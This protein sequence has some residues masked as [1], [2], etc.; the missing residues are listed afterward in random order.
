MVCISLDG[1]AA[2]GEL[3]LRLWN[4]LVECES[5]AAEDLASVAM[6]IERS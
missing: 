6:A 3:Q 5:T 2:L 1:I 4:D